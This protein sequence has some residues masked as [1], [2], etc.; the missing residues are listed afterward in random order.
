MAKCWGALF[1]LSAHG[2]LGALVYQSGRLGQ[3]VKGYTPQRYK[4]SASQ[5]DMNYAFGVTAENWHSLTDNQK[6]TYE[7]L[8]RGRNM[9]GFNIYIKKH[10]HDNLP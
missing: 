10:F 5:L 3:F 9:T 2:K 6:Q 7:D 8:A 1:S 4:P